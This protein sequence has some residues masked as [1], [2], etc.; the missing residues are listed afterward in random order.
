MT[1][2]SPF[3]VN[4]LV[5]STALTYA[6]LPPPKIMFTCTIAKDTFHRTVSLLVTSTSTLL[7]RCVAGMAQS[8]MLHCGGMLLRTTFGCRLIGTFWEMQDSRRATLSLSHT[9][10]CS[11]I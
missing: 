6:R 2:V 3:L 1:L 9:V 10:E 11:I 8:P 7:M 4:V 5:R